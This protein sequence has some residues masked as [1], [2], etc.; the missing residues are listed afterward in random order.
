MAVL[1]YNAVWFALPIAALATCIVDPLAAREAVV[2]VQRWTGQHSRALLLGA[3]FTV[4]VVL[5]VRGALLVA[6][7]AS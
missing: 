1:I 7:A 5:V 3:S 6:G 2:R 4:G